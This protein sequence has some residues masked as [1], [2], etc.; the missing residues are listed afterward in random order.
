MA[1][2]KQNSYSDLAPV[3]K[4]Q[5]QMVKSDYSYMSKVI[6]NLH[7]NYK[8]TTEECH[9]GKYIISESKFTKWSQAKAKEIS[10]NDKDMQAQIVAKMEA[11]QYVDVGQDKA[12]KIDLDYA[13]GGT[14]RLKCVFLA[15]KG[16][17]N[18]KY[19]VVYGLY[20]FQWAEADNW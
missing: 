2:Q 8:K 5:M 7:M 19:A 14:Q 10:P 4:E 15:V 3:A 6:S 16:L 12:I 18:D 9:N 13:W 11:L 17:P 20:S 1:L